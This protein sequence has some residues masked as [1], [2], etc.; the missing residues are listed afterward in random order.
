M[1][2]TAAATDTATSRQHASLQTE[3]TAPLPNQPL[4]PLI[5]PTHKG[6]HDRT[7][8]KKSDTFVAKIGRA[9]LFFYFLPPAPPP[10]SEIYAN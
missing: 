6:L 7:L 10:P 4:P 2:P 8:Q 3:A 1:W 9:V 5:N